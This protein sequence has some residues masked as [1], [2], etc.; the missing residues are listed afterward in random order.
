MMEGII[1]TLSEHDEAVGEVGRAVGAGIGRLGG[2][3]RRGYA[4]AT[5]RCSAPRRA[6]EGR[7]LPSG[8][9]RGP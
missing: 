2:A 7:R 1:L 3:V 5:D 9:D 4:G 6:G 8:T